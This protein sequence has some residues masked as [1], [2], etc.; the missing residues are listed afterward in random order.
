MKDKNTSGGKIKDFLA[1]AKDTEIEQALENPNL[2]AIITTILNTVVDNPATATILGSIIG[3]AAPRINSI[4]LNYKENRFERN[5][6]K[7]L[8]EIKEQIAELDSRV[9]TDD[10]LR[11]IV[12]GEMPL[13]LD[14]LYDEKQ[15]GKVKYHVSL[16]MNS[17]GQNVDESVLIDN[18]D[19][20]TQLTEMD[21]EVL[22][23][24]NPQHDD[25]N[26]FDIA[27]R[28]NIDEEQYRLT[29]EKL[30][31]FGL[32]NSK[33]DDIRDDNLEKIAEYL[34]KVDKENRKRNPKDV[35]IPK[36]NK[37][38]RSDSYSLSSAGRRFLQLI[39]LMKMYTPKAEE[40]AEIDAML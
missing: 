39:G 2:P 6:N 28:Y 32:L 3:G 38:R 17:M 31:R 11:R 34:D 5:V 24:Y 36:L 4:I 33:N 21:I 19:T 7:A 14:S 26:Y 40:Q 27:K 16:L 25:E 30:A 20:I 12:R 37:T 13:F 35:K 9:V 15:E 18:Y 29:R 22:N 10:Q 23:L 8:E 1:A